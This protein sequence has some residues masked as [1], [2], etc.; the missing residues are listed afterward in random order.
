MPCCSRGTSP[1]SRGPLGGVTSYYEANVER[2][3]ID[4]DA[5]RNV[6]YPSEAADLGL[7]IANVVGHPGHSLLS[8]SMRVRS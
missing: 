8:D 5:N 2:F 7:A 1:V 4:T 6:V 3:G